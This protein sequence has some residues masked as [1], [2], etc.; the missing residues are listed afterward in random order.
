MAQL[1]SFLTLI[2]AI[3]ALNCGD[4]SA[5]DYSGDGV[6]DLAFISIDSSGN[7]DWDVFTPLSGQSAGSISD[8]GVNGN[9]IISAPWSVAAGTNAGVISKD[10]TTGLVSW[11]VRNGTGAVE[12]KQFGKGSDLFVAGGDFNGNGTADAVIG[13]ARGSRMDWI[14]RRDYFASAVPLTKQRSFKFGNKS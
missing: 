8:F 12:Q 1:R 5:S 6:G 7:L 11:K 13:R 9:H 10:A 2:L 4:V 3:G 14:I